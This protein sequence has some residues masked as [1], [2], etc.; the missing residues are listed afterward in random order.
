MPASQPSALYEYEV[1]TPGTVRPERRSARRAE[2]KN[3]FKVRGLGLG[4]NTINLIDN[5]ASTDTKHNY[6][7]YH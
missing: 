3:F 7:C 2:R 5:I 4:K 6:T 1:E